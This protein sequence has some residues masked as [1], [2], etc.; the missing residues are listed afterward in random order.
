[1]LSNP[2]AILFIT[3]EKYGNVLNLPH[4]HPTG[5]LKRCNVFAQNHAKFS[6][7]S[8]TSVQQSLC[9]ILHFLQFQERNYN[10]VTEN[11][12]NRSL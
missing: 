9:K 8:I 6:R 1:M 11:I 2:F 5:N 7:N 12:V 10:G 4:M 3:Q